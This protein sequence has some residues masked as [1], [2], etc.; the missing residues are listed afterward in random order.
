VKAAGREFPFFIPV[1]ARPLPCRS[2]IGRLPPP[3][4]ICRARRRRQHRAARGSGAG[5]RTGGV[6][7]RSGSVRQSPRRFP[8]V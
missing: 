2:T 4:G 6:G 5:A 3:G 7:A 1:F 8:P